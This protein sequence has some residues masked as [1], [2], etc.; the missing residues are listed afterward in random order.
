MSSAGAELLPSRFVWCLDNFCCT[1][2]VLGMLQI[3][4]VFAQKWVVI[5]IDEVAKPQ[6]A[7]YATG[8]QLLHE[9]CSIVKSSDLQSNI[10]VAAI[11]INDGGSGVEVSV[12]RKQ[13]TNN[14]WTGGLQ[15]YS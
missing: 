10:G 7:L 15:Q 13:M 1:F 8:I 9:G 5:V 6:V 14:F 2:V 12:R 4:G 11:C 3:V